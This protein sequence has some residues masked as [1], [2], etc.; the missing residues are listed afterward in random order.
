MKQ[1]NGFTLLEVTASIALITIILISF[2]PLLINSK[3]IASSNI[4][5]LVIVNL[6]DATLSRLQST[7]F[8]YIDKPLDNPSYIYKNGISGEKTY[9]ASN[10]DV[11]NSCELYE[12][13]MNGQE[14]EVSIKVSQDI[15]ENRY[16]LIDVIVTV[17][18]QEK[19]IKYSVEG[20]LAYD[21][22][23]TQ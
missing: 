18:N 7:P 5:R 21:Q 19:K 1:E 8:S 3:S 11:D 10:C 9:S 16:G 23:S 13:I 14:Y 4:D 12:L 15:D 17:S 2:F 22:F 6:A 20:Y